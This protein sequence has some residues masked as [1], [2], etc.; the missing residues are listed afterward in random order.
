M[1]DPDINH[2]GSQAL[3]LFTAPFIGLLLENS[4]TPKRA[5]WVMGIAFLLFSPIFFSYYYTIH[6]AFRLLALVIIST[7]F[8]LYLKTLEE[9]KTKV[10]QSVVLSVVLF[11]PL[12]FMTIIDSFRGD[13][14][15][16]KTW[17]VHNYR[18]EYII[19]KGF[20]GKPLMT[21]DLSKYSFIPLLVKKVETIGDNDTDEN[22]FLEFPETGI[23]FDKCNKTISKKN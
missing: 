19:E 8:G 13:Q 1:S 17:H 22:C 18:I 5:K 6:Y 3:I 15:V 23:V 12:A 14:R 2:Y 7:A 16:V 20:S 9:M 4:L 11:L 10:L 21:Y